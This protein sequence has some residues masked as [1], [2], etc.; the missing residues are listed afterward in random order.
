MWLF[1]NI[2]FHILFLDGVYVYRDD[3]PPRF[4]RV[5][6]PDKSELEHLVELISQRAGRCLERLGLLE[7]DAESAWLELE[8]ADDT[9]GMPH[10]MGSSISYRVAVGPQQGRKAFMIRTIRP[11]DRP[12]PALARVAKANGFSLHAGVSCEGHQKDK[13]ER[14]CRYIARPAVAIPRLSLSSTGKRA[15]ASAISAHPAAIQ[16][17]TPAEQRDCGKKF[18][19]L[20]A[21]CFSYT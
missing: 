9:D 3:R 16:R 11:L 19:P 14:L 21:V 1:L 6:A 8:P 10:I 2:H 15:N 4:Q 18:F 12:D 17:S 7:Q 5:R 13:R 20:Y